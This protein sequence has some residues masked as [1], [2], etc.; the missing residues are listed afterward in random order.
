MPTVK[1]GLNSEFVQKTSW[2]W[3]KFLTAVTL[4]D[5]LENYFQDQPK[6]VRLGKVGLG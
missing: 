4:G 6:N 1:N 5:K 3:A 2:I